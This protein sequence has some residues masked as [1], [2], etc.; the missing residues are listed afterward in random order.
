VAEELVFT[1]Q[2]AAFLRE[3]VRNRVAFLIVGLASA[4]LQGAPAV[5]QDVDLWFQNLSDPGIRKALD[6]V[7][8]AYVPPIGGNPPMFAGGGV[9]LFD[10]VLRMDGLDSF[11][12]EFSRAIEIS[13]GRF[14]VKLLPLARIIASKKAA[15]R[16][17]DKL[18]IPML[19]NALLTLDAMKGPRPPRRKRS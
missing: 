12:R 13:L 17:K 10:I 3:L 6:R 15:N 19:E 2:E 7:G 16:S 5:T 14:K 4:A 8:A 11:S 1:E 9:E 18:T